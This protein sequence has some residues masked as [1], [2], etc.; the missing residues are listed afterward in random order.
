[1]I[2]GPGALPPLLATPKAEGC[3]FVGYGVIGLSF[4]DDE[5]PHEQE[6]AFWQGPVVPETVTPQSPAWP[7]HRLHNAANLCH[8]GRNVSGYQRYRVARIGDACSMMSRPCVRSEG[9]PSGAICHRTTAGRTY[10]RNLTNMARFGSCGPLPSQ[11]YHPTFGS[12]REKYALSTGFLRDF[13]DPA[14]HP[15]GERAFWHKAY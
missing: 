6:I 2:L 4:R 7:R 1:M 13:N 3:G 5:R 12:R 8:V 11:A 9:F 14:V 15:L 10:W